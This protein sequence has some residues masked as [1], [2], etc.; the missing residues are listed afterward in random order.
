MQQGSARMSVRTLTCFPDHWLIILYRNSKV[1]SLAAPKSTKVKFQHEIQK[2]FTGHMPIPHFCKCCSVSLQ[3]LRQ[4]PTLPQVSL[5][6]PHRLCQTWLSK[7]CDTSTCAL[8]ATVS[9]SSRTWNTMTSKLSDMDG[10]TSTLTVKPYSV[11]PA[12]I[13]H[14]SS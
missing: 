3:I 4:T 12:A 1:L 7:H 10:V 8:S 5:L 11:W 14:R 6:P 2:I 9:P 13:I